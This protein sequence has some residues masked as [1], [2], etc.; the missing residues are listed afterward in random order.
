MRLPSY[1]K[2]VG[3]S[4]NRNLPAVSRLGITPSHKENFD[5]EYL[6]TQGEYQKQR[7]EHQAGMTIAKAAV[8][9]GIDAVGQIISY[10]QQQAQKKAVTDATL[11][12]TYAETKFQ[13]YIRDYKKTPYAAGVD[14]AELYDTFK[15]D[16]QNE[17]ADMGGYEKQIFDQKFANLDL[18]YGSA[19]KDQVYDKE[20]AHQKAALTYALGQAVGN[21]NLDGIE[22]LLFG[23]TSGAQGAEKQERTAAISQ[24]DI[25]SEYPDHEVVGI[26]SGGWKLREVALNEDGS[27]DA[28]N[29]HS[30]YVTPRQLH[31]DGKITEAEYAAMKKPDTR[32]SGSIPGAVQMGLIGE[33][34]ALMYLDEAGYNVFR[35]KVFRQVQGS[36]ADPNVG[37]TE[38]LEALNTVD[39]DG[40]YVFEPTLRQE[41]RNTMASHLISQEN[42]R[43]GQIKINTTNFDDAAVGNFKL[44]YKN[45]QLKWAPLMAAAKNYGTLN[46]E[47]DQWDKDNPLKAINP[48]DAVQIVGWMESDQDA[49]DKA[50]ADKA[51]GTIGV[52]KDAL[53]SNFITLMAQIKDKTKPHME[54]DGLI[55]AANALGFITGPDKIKLLSENDLR[56]DDHILAGMLSALKDKGLNN[57]NKGRV[58]AILIP[59]YQKDYW[60]N[61]NIEEG[62]NPNRRAEQEWTDDL[63]I[64]TF[65]YLQNELVALIPGEEVSMWGAGMEGLRPKQKAAYLADVNSIDTVEKYEQA[66]G[67]GRMDHMAEAELARFKNLAMVVRQKQAAWY[68]DVANKYPA[69]EAAKKITLVGA[70]TVFTDVNDNSWEFIVTDQN[71]LLVNYTG[72]PIKDGSARTTAAG[73]QLIYM[74]GLWEYATTLKNRGEL[75]EI[76]T[77]TPGAGGTTS[78]QVFSNIARDAG[79]EDPWR[80]LGK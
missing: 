10:A 76:L 52:D 36:A 8:G 77:G 53:T 63:N 68:T 3:I 58:E 29:S 13:D 20:T 74:D 16:L 60:L 17:Y 54:M 23:E 35:N 62:P 59:L 44:A 51:S 28:E 50:E 6:R 38:T 72:A 39:A 71:E 43:L 75:R 12:A 57:V 61:G 1:H 33:S 37:N 56:N 19:Y 30:F 4:P 67:N 78:F 70:H 42:Y 5:E 9:A 80:T 41:D 24:F 26:S 66:V 2:K 27:E 65:P 47:T 14:T 7:A 79:E 32:E 64:M 21:E 31:R 18:K 40:N 55:T 45:G 69:V 49:F 22:S 34:E 25:A 48:S 11:K 46:F 15:M 73:R